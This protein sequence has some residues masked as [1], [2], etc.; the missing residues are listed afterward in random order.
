M[1]L[2]YVKYHV[3]EAPR[4]KTDIQT[5]LNYT[6]KAVVTYLLDLYGVIYD[7]IPIETINAGFKENY[8]ESLPPILATGEQQIT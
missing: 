1:Y 7:H 4:Y 2:P 3:K 6:D 5:L 8:S